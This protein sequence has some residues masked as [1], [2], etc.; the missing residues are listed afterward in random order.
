MDWK[1]NCSL[2]CQSLLSKWTQKHIVHW[3]IE[4]PRCVQWEMPF[5]SSEHAPDA[6][7]SQRCPGYFYPLSSSTR[8]Y[9]LADSISKRVRIKKQ[10]DKRKEN[11]KRGRSQVPSAQILFHPPGQKL[12]WHGQEDLWH[13]EQ[14]N[15]VSFGTKTS[16]F[17]FLRSQ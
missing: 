11:K 8:T 1:T 17:H 15:S 7:P 6:L 9:V 12:L 16:T 13:Q 10:V 4:V 3:Q 2:V 5:M 14:A